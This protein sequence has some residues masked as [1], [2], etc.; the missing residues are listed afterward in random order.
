[1]NLPDDTELLSAYA[2][3]G[4][5]EAF[6]ML[7]ERHVSLVY[8]SAVRQ[9]RDPHLAQEITQAV[10]II[11]AR[12]AGGLSK[13]TVLPGWLC[14]SAHFAAC[15]ALKAE[16]RRRQHER[17]ACTESLLQ[18]SEGEVWTQIEPL[19]DEAVAQ[20]SEADRN[21]VVLRFYEQRPPEEVGRVLGLNADTAQKRVS[22]AL[23][24]LRRFF[25]KRGVGVTMTIIAGA[26]PAKS[27]Q[28]APAGLAQTVT[29]VA[30]AKGTAAGGSTPSL[31][32]GALKLMAWS[33]TKTTVLAGVCVLLAL[34]STTAV[35]ITANRSPMDAPDQFRYVRGEPADPRHK[36]Q[37]EYWRSHTWPAETQRE[38]ARIRSRQTTNETVNAATIDLKPYTNAALTDSPVSSAGDNANNLSELPSGTHIFAG[39]PFDV[40]GSIQLMGTGLRSF[41]KNYPAEVDNIRIGRRC[42]KLHLLHGANWVYTSE[43]GTLAAELVLHYTDGSTNTIEMVTGKTVFDWWGPLFQTGVDPRFYQM[44]SGTERAWTGSNPFIKRSWKDESLILYKTTLENP[45]PDMPVSSLD[46]VS[47]MREVAPFLVGLTVE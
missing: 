26:L 3:R 4:S 8:S 29:A 23:E 37:L 27:V 32:K 41:A 33:K 20:L 11:L 42:A 25:A 47:A 1:M 2:T 18:A 28:A 10:F 31:V 40:E 38:V 21:A 44:P 30:V 39:V 34:V 6:A 12:K 24:K 7:V 17:E 16:H 22:R 13:G 35:L 45:K 15:N 43:F 14:R 5:E 46:Y 9:V 36:A 19:L